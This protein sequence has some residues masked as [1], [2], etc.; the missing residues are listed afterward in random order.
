MFFH[1]FQF[2]DWRKHPDEPTFSEKRW[3]KS[4]S[5]LDW[6][7]NQDTRFIAEEGIEHIEEN[8]NDPVGRLDRS[9][10]ILPY[11]Y[12]SLRA[13]ETIWQRITLNV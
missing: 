10:G 3:K 12:F 1:S 11:Y 13:I 2:L 9:K 8:R 5:N 4:I 7:L 6:L